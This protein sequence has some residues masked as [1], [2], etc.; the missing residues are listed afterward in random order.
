MQRFIKQILLDEIGFLGQK[1]LQ[2]AKILLIGLGGLGCPTALYLG[3]AGIGTVGI[4]EF[5]VVDMSNLH[6]QILYTEEDLGKNKIDVGIQKLS[7]QFPATI[8][9]KH[10][11]KVSN[12]NI[13]DLVRNYDLI[14]DGSDNF[15]TRFIVND[16][17]VRQNI[18]LLFGSILGFEAQFCLFDNPAK[19]NYRTLYPEA[20]EYVPSCSENGVLSPCTGIIGSI[21]ANIACLY[22]MN[23]YTEQNTLKCIHLLNLKMQ[24]VRIT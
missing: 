13:D 20:P 3:G 10:A 8:W 7:A 24:S 23:L 9:N 21:L 11:L 1:K 17:C 14:I 16:A 18:P 6:R 4:A 12:E 5:D 19:S 2:S 22:H 15:T